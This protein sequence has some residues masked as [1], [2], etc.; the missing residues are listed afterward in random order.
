MDNVWVHIL[1]LIPIEF[2][3]LHA[4]PLG[5]ML[6]SGFQEMFGA[7]GFEFANAAAHGAPGHVCALDYA[8]ENAAVPAF[9][10]SGDA[11]VPSPSGP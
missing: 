6:V 2:G 4:T 9:E 8:L 10:F 7:L 11:L 3:I 1:I 5:G